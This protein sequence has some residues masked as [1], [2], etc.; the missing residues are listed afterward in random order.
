[1]Y[2]R[3]CICCGQV[4]ENRIT[5]EN[6]NVCVRCSDLDW[7]DEAAVGLSD[8]PLPAL[9]PT[10]SGTEIP[11]QQPA[12]AEN[13]SGWHHVDDFKEPSAIDFLEAEIAAKK[14]IAEAA[15][16]EARALEQKLFDLIQHPPKI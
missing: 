7:D 14:I 4:V 6:P 13:P 1:M 3:L 2:S 8:E 5:G 12:L 10:L 9:L 11:H 15:A 16:R